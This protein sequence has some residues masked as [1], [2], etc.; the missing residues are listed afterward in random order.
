MRPLPR[1]IAV[2]D[3]ETCQATDFPIWAAAVLSLGPIAGVLVQTVAAPPEFTRKQLIR[4]RALA[5]PAEAATFAYGDPDLARATGVQGL[6]LPADGVAVTRA[7]SVFGGPIGVMINSPGEAAD[8]V[9][10]RCDFLLAARMPL[11]QATTL[12]RSG[13]PAAA[14]KWGG[15]IY[16]DGDGPRDQLLRARAEGAYGLVTSRSIWGAADPVEATIA[17][18]AD[19][20]QS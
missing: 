5:R 3:D 18:L 8:A 12:V 17:L 19:W 4:I 16:V 10:Q 11:A 9:R 7:R 2:A 13:S 6:V 14:G 1:L 20:E 15:L